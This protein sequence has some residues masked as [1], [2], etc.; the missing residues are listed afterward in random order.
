MLLSLRT[1]TE[2]CLKILSSW[3]LSKAVLVK[4]CLMV[5][6]F[7]PLK[8]LD[9][10]AR[11]ITASK[12]GNL[13]Q[14]LCLKLLWE[15]SGKPHLWYSLLNLSNYSSDVGRSLFLGLLMDILNLRWYSGFSNWLCFPEIW[16]V[17]PWKHRKIYQLPSWCVPICPTTVEG[18]QGKSSTSEDKWVLFRNG[19]QEMVKGHN[20]SSS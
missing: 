10:C 18:K 17:S 6:S 12:P 7:P 13:L 16:I 3:C 19:F 20:N 5:I 2:K 9:F 1:V 14:N 15:F 4:F 8:T 11:E